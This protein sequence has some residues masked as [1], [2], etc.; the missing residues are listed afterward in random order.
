[1]DLIEVNDFNVIYDDRSIEYLM[2][3]GDINLEGSGDFTADVYDL[4]IKMDAL[5]ADIAYEGVDYLTNKHFRAETNMN[6]DMANMKFTFGEGEFG[7]NDFFL[8]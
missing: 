4:P 8:T 1:V 2:A 5:I 7:L 6:I 3:L